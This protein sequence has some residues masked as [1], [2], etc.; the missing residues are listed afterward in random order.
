MRYSEVSMD[1]LITEQAVARHWWDDVR[2]AIRGSHRSYTEGPIGRA[3]LMLAVPMVLETVMESLFAVV[4]VFFVAKLGA[5][6]VATVGLTET[7]LYILYSIAMGL[8]IGA[9]AIVARRIGEKDPD[10]AAKAAV[11]A[12]ILGAGI[13]AIIAIV[14]LTTAPFLLHSLGGSEAVQRNGANYTRIMLGGNIVI[15]MLYLINAI[16]RGA[17]DAAIAMR[18]LA[19]ANGI[20]ILLGPCLIFGLGPFPEL[21]VTG[22][23][24]ATRRAR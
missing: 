11:Q 10:G 22:A 9:T 17:W 5:D 19:I 24:V 13:A 20:N 12:I 1:S 8:G 2:E 14:G 6:A 21:G 7:M 16:F 3:L 15:I 18:V 4:D 23:A